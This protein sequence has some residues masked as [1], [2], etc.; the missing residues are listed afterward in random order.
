M[1]TTEKILLT[2]LTLLITLAAWLGY[3]AFAVLP[4]IL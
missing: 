4:D 3:Q 2:L 1:S